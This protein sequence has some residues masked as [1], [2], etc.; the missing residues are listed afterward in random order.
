MQECYLEHTLIIELVL[1]VTIKKIQQG[2]FLRID[3]YRLT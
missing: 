2:L 1:V 3:F